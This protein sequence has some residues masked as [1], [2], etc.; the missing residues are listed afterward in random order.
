VLQLGLPDR[1]GD[2]GDPALHSQACGSNKDAYSPASGAVELRSLSDKL[3][4]TKASGQAHYSD[5]AAE[6]EMDGYEK[7]T[8]T[9]AYLTRIADRYREILKDPARIPSAKAGENPEARS[10]RA[11]V[12]DSRLR[13]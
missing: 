2:H 11:A 7:M 3:L 5:K 6:N 1:Y 13:S 4:Y 9:T 10:P 8:S 12:P